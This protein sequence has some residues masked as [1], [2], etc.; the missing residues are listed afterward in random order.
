MKREN[1]P[2]LAGVLVPVFEKHPTV[3][4]SYRGGRPVQMTIEPEVVIDQ[5]RVTYFS[6]PAYWIQTMLHY[7]RYIFS[8]C[9]MKEER[10]L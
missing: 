5:R 6:D 9:E 4:K 10:N 2:G 1:S 7:R 3:W 8:A